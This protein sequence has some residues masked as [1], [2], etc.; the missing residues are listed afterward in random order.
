MN[1]P[2]TQI[3]KNSNHPSRGDVVRYYI[4]LFLSRGAYTR[5]LGLFALSAGLV[6][7]CSILA[8]LV[9]PSDSEQGGNF[10]EAVWWSTMRVIDAG[11]MAGDTGIL[12]RLI[13]ALST[14]SGIVVVALLKW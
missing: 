7:L 11:N 10:F 8:L 12:V 2:K 13:A 6:F 4:D 9:S 5:F 1:G 14:L 3:E